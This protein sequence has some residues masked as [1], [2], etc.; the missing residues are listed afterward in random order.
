[1][2]DRYDR[3]GVC[4]S[5]EAVENN[6]GDYTPEMKTTI[7]EGMHVSEHAKST[8]RTVDGGNKDASS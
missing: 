6:A 7:T 2:S 4:W 5:A 1:M 3:M 8:V